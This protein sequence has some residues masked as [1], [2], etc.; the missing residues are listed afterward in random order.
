MRCTEQDAEAGR[1]AFEFASTKQFY[2]Q[3]LNTS[4][5]GGAPVPTGMANASAEG[6]RSISVRTRR[7]LLES[8]AE[9]ERNGGETVRAGREV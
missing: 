4:V 9:A 6:P 7:N 1:R 3:G 8:D 2:E 5:D